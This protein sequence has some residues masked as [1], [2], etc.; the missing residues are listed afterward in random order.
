MSQEDLKA[1]VRD[2]K[3]LRSL[4]QRFE[5]LRQ[6]VHF[7]KPI[8]PGPLGAGIR[9]EDG[10][11]SVIARKRLREALGDEEFDRV[12]RIY[13]G[14]PHHRLVIGEVGSESTWAEV[15]GM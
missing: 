1:L 14:T 8:E 3:G 15:T 11:P 12:M 4:S 5:K 10:V 2:L 9:V 13:G 6:V 7:D